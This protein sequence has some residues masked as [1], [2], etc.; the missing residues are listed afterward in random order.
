MRNLLILVV[1]FH[2]VACGP[3]L[4]SSRLDSLLTK[5]PQVLL[6]QPTNNQVVAPNTKII[7]LFSQAIDPASVSQ[8]NFA[9]LKMPDQE[10]DINDIVDDL[11]DRDIAG[12]DGAY[13]FA[14][15]H[16]QVIFKPADL[17]ES[18]EYLI[19][20]TPEITTLAAIPL[21]QQPGE[22]PT[23][24]WGSFQVNAESAIAQNAEGE[25]SLENEEAEQSEAQDVV[26]IRPSFLILNEILYDAAGDETD[27]HLF[28]ELLGE[29]GTDIS[30]FSIVFINGAN[31]AETENINIPEDSI[32]PEDG[33]FLIADTRTGAPD[34]TNVAEAD[35]L[36]NFDPQ[37]G[38]DCVQL[39]DHNHVLLD[40]VGYGTPLSETAE[41]DLACFETL[42]TEDASAGQSISRISGVDTDNNAN[43]FI[44]F[45]EPTPGI[46]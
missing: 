22:A 33:I 13:D 32:I 30:N 41:N 10:L 40:S 28:V 45:L 15:D 34:Q 42:P 17:L 18:G 31:G 20:I 16:K 27:G 11:E 9:V 21:N 3:A 25:A 46:E 1:M 29:P 35:L 6:T 14:E 36:D 19:V 23:A 2:L 39:L 24:Y 8:Q 43:D 44:V 38:P 5:Q 4:T 37:N 12:L 26:R 7:A